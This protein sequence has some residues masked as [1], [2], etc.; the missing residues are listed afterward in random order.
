MGPPDMTTPSAHPKKKAS[1]N[2]FHLLGRKQSLRDDELQAGDAQSQ[3]RSQ[4]SRQRT[5]RLKEKSS[6][7]R[8]R[9]LDRQAGNEDSALHGNGQHAHGQH[10]SIIKTTGSRAVGAAKGLLGKFSKGGGGDTKDPAERVRQAREEEAQKAAR[11]K[12]YR[13]VNLPLEQQTRLTRICK[14][15]E[16][17]K[18]KTEFWLPAVAYRC[19]DYL[20][21]KGMSHEGLYR[22]PGS[23]REIRNWIYRF[24]T[25]TFL[26][27][28]W[29]SA[30]FE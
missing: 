17:C 9:S 7:V 14:K 23:E 22:V 19:I 28:T 4:A 20:N 11:T 12:S 16:D 26:A 3:G 6:A 27:T 18:D 25:G 13:V 10:S 21:D 5:E 24:D 8:N 15:L 2:K 1:R 30:N 29:N